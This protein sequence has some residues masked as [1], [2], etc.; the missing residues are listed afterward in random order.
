M[1]PYIQPDSY[2]ISHHLIHPFFLKKGKIIKVKH[3]L[4]GLIVKRIIDVDQQGYYWLEG[5]NKNSI[6][7]LEMGAIDFKMIIG[8]IIYII[9]PKSTKIN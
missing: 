7:T 6:S 5:L 4:F 2:L 3:P 9:K 1:S 8:V